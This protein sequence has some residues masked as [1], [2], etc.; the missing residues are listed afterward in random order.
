M[1]QTSKWNQELRDILTKNKS[2]SNRKLLWLIIFTGIMTTL[3][4]Y[5]VVTGIINFIVTALVTVIL[6][7]ITCLVIGYIL[8]G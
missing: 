8:F 2:I 1:H 3:I 5:I 6:C 7:I 4:F